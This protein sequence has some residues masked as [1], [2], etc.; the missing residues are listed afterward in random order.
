[1]KQKQK[2]LDRKYNLEKLERTKNERLMTATGS[3]ASSLG[4]AYARQQRYSNGG[5]WDF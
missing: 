4:K 2:E 3:L 1:M 5:S